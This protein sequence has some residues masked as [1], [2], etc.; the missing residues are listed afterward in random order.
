MRVLPQ[1][2]LIFFL[3]C[4]TL[5]KY[6]FHH[7]QQEHCQVGVYVS[8]HSPDT[9][10]PQSRP[11]SRPLSGAD[12]IIPTTDS[13]NLDANINDDI[14]TSNNKSD[15]AA[16]EDHHYESGKEEEEENDHYEI[17]VACQQLPS[18]H[19]GDWTPGSPSKAPDGTPSITSTTG[20]VE[21]LFDT[22]SADGIV[23]TPP[24]VPPP[25]PPRRDANVRWSDSE[26]RAPLSGGLDSSGGV[27]WGGSGDVPPELPFRPAQLPRRGEMVISGG[28]L[29]SDKSEASEKSDDRSDGEISG[30]S[31][32]S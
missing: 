14:V 28:A 25:L 29:R 30:D 18:N 22:G 10:R 17:P 6:S 9:S 32:V 20:S 7:Y 13:D 5:S 31:L 21:E 12:L 4:E 19:D 26:L 11:Q 3:K 27:K 8:P 23:G 15:E 24:P 1:R 2:V 16:E